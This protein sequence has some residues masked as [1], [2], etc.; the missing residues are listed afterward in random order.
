MTPPHSSSSGNKSFAVYVIMYTIVLASLALDIQ[1]GGILFTL[2]G[3]ASSILLTT[4]IAYQMA[5]AMSVSP[6]DSRVA[7]LPAPERAQVA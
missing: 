4:L 2:V 7:P 3:I 1:R 6:T 5:Q